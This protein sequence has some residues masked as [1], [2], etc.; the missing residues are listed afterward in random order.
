MTKKKFLRIKTNDL[1]H[2]LYVAADKTLNNIPGFGGSNRETTYGLMK[3]D[4]ASLKHNSKSGLTDFQKNMILLSTGMS[5]VA[6]RRHPSVPE[7]KEIW[8]KQGRGRKPWSYNKIFLQG[9]V[10]PEQGA[11]HHRRGH[12]AILIEIS[13]NIPNEPDSID[14]WDSGHFTYKYLLRAHQAWLAAEGYHRE[15]PG[16]GNLVERYHWEGVVQRDPFNCGQYMLINAHYRFRWQVP[17]LTGYIP[18]R[19]EPDHRHF[20]TDKRYLWGRKDDQG[21]LVYPE[22]DKVTLKLAQKKE[23]DY[24]RMK[25][26][27]IKQ[28]R[29]FK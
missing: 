26:W 11:D 10:E 9:G 14:I 1:E 4:M 5:V 22:L 20:G 12:H 19:S 15:R 2:Y 13:F 17:N 16:T 24:R 18:P 28:F 25:K 27:Q 7:M 3:E 23:A 21:N 29:G 8:S 6:D